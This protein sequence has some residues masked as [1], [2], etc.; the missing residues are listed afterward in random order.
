MT[1][2]DINTATSSTLDQQGQ[3]RFEQIIADDSRMEPTDWMPEK[4]RKTLVRQMSQHAHAEIIGIQPEANWITRGTAR[5][6]GK[7]LFNFQLSST[8]LGRY[9]S[10]WLAC[11]RCSDLQSGSALPCIVCTVWACDGAN[12]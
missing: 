1:A 7:I 2:T 11:R 8:H 12:L 5:R 9:W 10:N 4:Y 6:E 3:E